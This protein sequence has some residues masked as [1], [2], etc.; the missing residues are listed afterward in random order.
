M[1][2]F[3]EYIVKPPKDYKKLKRRK[4]RL[5]VFYCA[6]CVITFACVFF[7]FLNRFLVPFLVVIAILTY[8]MIRF[9]WPKTKPV[10]EISIELGVLCVAV[11]YG[12]RMR[13]VILKTE[14]KDAELIAPTNGMYENKIKDFAPEKEYNAAFV[15]GQKNYFML[16][17]NENDQKSILYFDADVDQI[18]HFRRLNART[19]VNRSSN[20]ENE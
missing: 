3:F 17:V 5:A 11:I 15:D 6:F 16:F 4:I 8:F 20:K 1:E 7:T 18:G 10:Y 13:R 2:T 14:V 9:T 12:G 19:Y